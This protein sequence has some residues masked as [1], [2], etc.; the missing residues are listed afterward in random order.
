MQLKFSRTGR[1]YLSRKELK[2]SVVFSRSPLTLAGGFYLM[3]DPVS[4]ILFQE[5]FVDGRGAG[6]F[7]DIL[8]MNADSDA[9]DLDLKNLSL[10]DFISIRDLQELQD[11]FARANR[12]A[13]T[14]TDLDGEPIT[15]PSNHCAVCTLIR[16]TKKGLENCRTSGRTLGRLSLNRNIPES[17]YCLSVGFLDAAA[18]IVVGG[19]HM[20]NWLIGQNAIG[21]VD[22]ERILAYASEIDAD[23]ESMLKAFREMRVIPEEVFREKLD[24]LWL[25]ANQIADLAFQNFRYQ[26]VLRTLEKSQKK[27]REYRD[28]LEITIQKRTASLKT[29]NA[30][31][32]SEIRGRKIIEKERE[33][34][35]LDLK[36]AI[37]K[38]KTLSGMLPICSYCKK[39]RDDTGYWNQI[40]SYIHM[41]SDVDFSHSI[42]PECA[43]KHY[44]DLDFKDLGKE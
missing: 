24:F 17:H 3:R 6:I 44:P 23:R 22:E 19:I 5:A 16:S 25:M 41:H 39:I 21:N 36:N 18:P 43:R 1:R 15:R 8:F 30:K 20:A 12:I 40:E 34:L 14:I 9:E 37:G 33:R 11:S 38:I 28:N 29:T 32:E 26:K 7:G 42:C 10:T 2:R 31:L 27:L 4:F 35:I 13:S